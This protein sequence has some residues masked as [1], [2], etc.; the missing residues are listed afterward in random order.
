MNKIVHIKIFNDI[1]DQFFT[2]LEDNFADFKSDIVLTRSA[3]EF[4]RRS[5]PRLVVETFMKS[6]GP[7]VKQIFSCDEDFFLNFQ[8]DVKNGVSD[9]NAILANKIKK[10][11]LSKD[12]T[13]THK[14]YIWL[15]F[16]KLVKAGEKVMD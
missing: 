2:Y 11:W 9:A 12:V 8:M 5:N 7:F 14:A 4:M 3:T 6:S 1:L 10:I 13:D 15:H 16:Q